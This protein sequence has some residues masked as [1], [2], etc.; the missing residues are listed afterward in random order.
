[1]LL[2]RQACGLEMLLRPIGL[3]LAERAADG[4]DTAQRLVQLAQLRNPAC[5]PTEAAFPERLRQWGPALRLERARAGQRGRQLRVTRHAARNVSYRLAESSV[6][7]R[8]A[9]SPAWCQPRSQHTVRWRCH[10]SSS[11]TRAG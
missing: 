3:H 2:A 7:G 9:A 10:Q 4:A 6:I 8:Q 11:K 1:D 5:Q